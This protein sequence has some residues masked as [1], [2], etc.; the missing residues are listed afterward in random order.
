M[1]AGVAGVLACAALALLAHPSALFGR[2][3]AASGTVSADAEQVAVVD[4]ETL[5]LRDKV[6]RLQ[7]VTA[8]PRG[9]TCA[10]HDCG[11]EAA[12]ALSGLVRDHGVA[13]R[14]NGTDRLGFPKGVCKAG[15]TDL[16][17]QL[18]LAGFARAAGP[19][20]AREERDAR[21]RGRGLWRLG[22]SF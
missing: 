1:V 16:G 2:V 6:V 19:E 14:M 21:A 11:R 7:G 18:V 22:L 5:R 9:D 13:C 15:G 4:G 10:G 12:E 17:R 20:L 3:P 8:P